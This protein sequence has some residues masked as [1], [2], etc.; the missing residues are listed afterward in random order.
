[1]RYNGFSGFNGYN[2]FRG[3]MGAKGEKVYG[4]GFK[5][6][7]SRGM[8]LLDSMLHCLNQDLLDYRIA[9]MRHNST[10]KNHSIIIFSCDINLSL[11]S[12]IRT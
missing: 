4:T 6:Y 1:M 5:G 9:R 8:V 3:A 10:F 2:G 7:G 11:S 12:E